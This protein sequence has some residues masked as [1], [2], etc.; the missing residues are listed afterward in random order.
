MRTVAWAGVALALAL[1]AGC[2]DRDHRDADDQV[3]ASADRAG[4]AVDRAANDAG[5]AAKDAGNDVKEAARDVGDEVG[6]TSYERRDEFR[7]E[8]DSRLAAMDKEL[9]ELKAHVNKDATEAYRNG[10]A[11]ASETRRTVGEDVNRLSGATAANW[12]ELK[13]RV[14]VSL[15]SL[16]RQLRAMRPDA[17]PMGGAG[18]S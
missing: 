3:A 7:K 2:K 15:D 10:V 9:G 13:S 14:R 18:P 17:R 1:T 11:A 12:D 8:V 4:D 5:D 16:D 6:A